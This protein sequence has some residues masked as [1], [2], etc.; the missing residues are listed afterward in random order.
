MRHAVSAAMGA[1]LTVSTTVAR[2]VPPPE[3][4]TVKLELPQP[5]VVGVAKVPRPKP[6]KT[7]VTEAPTARAVVQPANLKETEEDTPGQT[8]ECPGATLS[9][10]P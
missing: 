6:G 9:S 1:T 7:S 5:V 2:A 8:T 3:L 4:E 10:V